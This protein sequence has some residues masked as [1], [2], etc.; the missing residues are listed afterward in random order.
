MFLTILFPKTLKPR[1][2]LYLLL[3]FGAAAAQQD[4][5]LEVEGFGTN[6]GNISLFYY[7][8]PNLPA[9][10][11]MVVVVHGCSQSAASVNRL[12]GWTTLADRYGFY[13]LFPQQH[14]TN[15]P[16]HC[17]DWFKMS[18]I[19][20]GKGECESIRQMI[21]YMQSRFSIDA[22]RVSIT[23][24]SA[25][26]AMSV[27]MIAA[28]PELF[29]GAAIFAG[30][31]YKPGENYVSAMSSMLSMPVKTPDEWRR[32]VWEQNPAFKGP[33][34]KVFVFQGNSD[35][36]VPPQS[37]I[38]LVKQWTALHGTDTLADAVEKSYGGCAD[39][40]RKSYRDPAGAEVVALYTIDR[41]GHALPVNPGP[42]HNQGGRKGMFGTVKN[43]Y[44]TYYAAADLGLIAGFVPEGKT[45]AQPYE[46]DLVFSVKGEPGSVYLWTLP[47]GCSIVGPDDGASIHVN[48][49]DAPGEV[50]VEEVSGAGCR[51]YHPKLQVKLTNK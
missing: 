43:F 7:A 19:E 9:N 5:L 48:W 20:R 4:T 27:A 35:R 22:R 50:S 40:C 32:V 25:G 21:G 14:I 8:P 10:A 15:N 28:Y 18:D 30:C 6:P 29:S 12:T 39:V 38:E 49:N 26:A 13:V 16:S 24:L 44:S 45:G 11:P 2:L 47:A 42:C 36:V 1:I 23:G 51:Y 17:F 3:C 46:K 31:P 33:Y 37:A 41:L 34:P